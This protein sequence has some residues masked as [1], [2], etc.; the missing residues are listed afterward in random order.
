[1]NSIITQ[2]KQ[3]FPDRNLRKLLRNWKLLT[4]RKILYF[5]HIFSPGEKRFLLLFLAVALFSGSVFFLRLY[6]KNTYV[7]P[8]VGKTYVEGMQKE[9]R[10]INPIYVT[11]DGD[12]DIARL[13]FSSLFTYS[14][15]GRFEPDAAEG[16]EIS[17]D[18]K[19][20][21]VELK[22]NIY[23]HDGGQLTADDVIF[24]VK[25][26]QNALYKSPRRAN[27]QGVEVEK[28]D[29]YTL[30]FNL[31]SP[32]APFIENLT[33]GI[34]PKH[35][36]EGIGPEQAL[37][38]ELNLKPIG[39]G[40]YKFGNL[41]QAK[42]GS[43]TSYELR[44]NPNYY[45][46]GPWLKKIIFVFFKSEEEMLAAWQKERID[47]F[48]PFPASRSKDLARETIKIMPITMP[49]LFGLFFN[50]KK[51]ESLADKNVRQAIA[52]ALNKKEIAAN[53]PSSG[54]I[55]VDSILPLGSPGYTNEITKYPYDP[56]KS[57]ALL[58]SAGWKDENGDGVR[59]KVLKKGGKTEIIPLS[60]SLTTSDWP[61]LLKTAA[62][63]QAALR[64]IGIEIV[65]QKY[66]LS[67]LESAVIR[68]RNFAILLFGQVY[69]YEPDPFAFWHSSQIKDP[70]LNIALYANKK[71]DQILEE[72]RRL[73]DLG[74]REAKYMELQRIIASD[75]PAVFLYSQLYLYALPENISGVEISK[76]S[77]PADRFNE[78][79]KWYIETRRV[80]K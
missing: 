77:L 60:L 64:E 46:E 21:T 49:R 61:D 26:I 56:E 67:E 71:A 18:G 65:I 10:N 20:Y 27:W 22:K 40:P 8:Q 80:F 42:D 6:L 78:I 51:D 30:R 17:T 31:R 52:H 69:G 43:I 25:T 35:L 76:I 50:E 14:G 55:P 29:T 12:R 23:W 16:L 48:G 41:R 13:V 53:V 70:G 34:L 58:E 72:S 44:Q 3:F 28:V 19:V 75:I 1:M 74:E 73:S 57:R 66:S 68:P 11:T 54:A 36:W 63:V 5:P 38:H 59:E 39:S 2:L 4:A 37:L 79:N 9:P 7:T 32:Y 15:E 62:A 47:G 33:L 24:T 45:G